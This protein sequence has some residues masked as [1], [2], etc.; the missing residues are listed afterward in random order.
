MLAKY[1][2][3]FASNDQ[4]MDSKRVLLA[5][6]SVLGQTPRNPILPIGFSFFTLKLTSA[7][8]HSSPRV[9]LLNLLFIDET[10]DNITA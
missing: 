6:V 9:L 7:W 8:C 5:K 1:E 4:K 2:Q 10:L 3:L